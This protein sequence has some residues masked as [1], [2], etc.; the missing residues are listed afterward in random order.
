MFI[1]CDP[2]TLNLKSNGKW[3]TCYIELPKGYDVTQID[4]STISLNGIPVYL[5]KEGWAKGKATESNI[6]DHDNDGILER[7]VKFE[8]EKVQKILE[9]EENAELIINGKVFYH[10]RLTDFEGRDT[11]RVIN[12]NNGKIK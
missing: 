6:M 5:G 4:G 1:D 12:K 9:P 2:D 3:I 11:I 7:M 10:Q 8:R